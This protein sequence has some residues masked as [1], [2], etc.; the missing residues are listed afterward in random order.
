MVGATRESD[1][2]QVECILTRTAKRELWKLRAFEGRKEEEKSVR[3][4]V[5]VGESAAC[6]ATWPGK[7]SKQDKKASGPNVTGRPGGRSIQQRGPQGCGDTSSGKHWGE[8]VYLA[9]CQ[10][11]RN[12]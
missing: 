10:L 11:S 1:I 9:V 2:A 5:V 3:S 8:T 4:S 6:T 7:R 12:K